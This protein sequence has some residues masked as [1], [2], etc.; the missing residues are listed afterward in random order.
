MVSFKIIVQ[1]S[2]RREL[3]SLPPQVQKRI[4]FKIE[5]L[6]KEPLPQGAKKIRGKKSVFRLRI[7]VYRII[8]EIDFKNQIITIFRIRHRKDVYSI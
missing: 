7:G 4:Y 3:R 2:A 6:A 8:Y 1:T 5:N